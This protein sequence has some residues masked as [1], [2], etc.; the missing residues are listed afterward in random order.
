MQN[1]CLYYWPCDKLFGL[2]SVLI[3]FDLFVE[4]Q[5]FFDCFVF[6]RVSESR[7][8]MSREP[9]GGGVI[10]SLYYNISVLFI[11]LI[12]VLGGLLKLAFCRSFFNLTLSSSHHCH[13]IQQTPPAW[14]ATLAWPCCFSLHCVNRWML[15]LLMPLLLFLLHYTLFIV[16]VLPINSFVEPLVSLSF[17]HSDKLVGLLILWITRINSVAL[18]LLLSFYQ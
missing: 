14:P 6:M 7:V 11:I 3:Q 12:T 4:I 8:M 15:W 17:D 1:R 5:S 9:H 13:L 18:L 16:V 2:V 10:F